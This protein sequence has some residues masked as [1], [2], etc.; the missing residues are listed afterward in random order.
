MA[1]QPGTAPGA[2]EPRCKCC[3]CVPCPGGLFNWTGCECPQTYA[4]VNLSAV[5]I[6]IGTTWTLTRGNLDFNSPGYGV[7]EVYTVVA[8]E[9]LQNVICLGEFEGRN[10]QQFGNITIVNDLGYHI[11]RPVVVQ[12]VLAGGTLT[13][14]IFAPGSFGL[15]TGVAAGSVGIANT[16]IRILQYSA[17]YIS[18]CASI[19]IPIAEAVGSTDAVPGGFTGPFLTPPQYTLWAGR[20][21]ARVTPGCCERCVPAAPVADCPGEW[22]DPGAFAFPAGARDLAPWGTGMPGV[23]IPP[24]CQ[25]SPFVPRTA[26]VTVDVSLC[27]GCWH[28]QNQNGFWNH[29]VISGPSTFSADECVDLTQ[30]QQG[31]LIQENA[32]QVSSWTNADPTDCTV[33]GGAATTQSYHVYLSAYYAFGAL[34]VELVAIRAG[35]LGGPPPPAP[36]TLPPNL[37]RPLNGNSFLF[38]SSIPLLCSDL[39]PGNSVSGGNLGACDP[40]TLPFADE[41][42]DSTFWGTGGVASA[43]FCCI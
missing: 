19:S 39:V 22:I 12:A 27:V 14:D 1:L 18:G 28:V 6:P 36:A 24:R 31:M 38:S 29:V 32:F 43:V 35:S 10:S 11:T 7:D 4:T 15:F 20:G 2:W 37:T 5:D 26:R 25:C 3:G 16:F 42:G 40:A 34:R 41:S 33:P 30:A 9:R 21:S 8:F 23:S 17:P 13:V